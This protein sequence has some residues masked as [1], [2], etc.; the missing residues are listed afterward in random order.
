M[1]CCFRSLFCSW[2]ELVAV[3]V[4]LKDVFMNKPGR[5]QVVSKLWFEV[6]PAPE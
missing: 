5:T 4:F 3:E 2:F 1:G 6:S